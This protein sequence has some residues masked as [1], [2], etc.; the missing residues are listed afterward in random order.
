M[1]TKD[2][3]ETRDKWV[4]CQVTIIK[5]KDDCY[6]IHS[7]VGPTDVSTQWFLATHVRKAP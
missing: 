5:V 2:K 7:N 4:N 3:E 6:L 1:L